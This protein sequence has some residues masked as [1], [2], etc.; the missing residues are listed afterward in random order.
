MSVPILATKLYILPPRPNVV[1]R[2]RLIERLN[3]GLGQ[4]QSF[5]RKLTLIS[6]PAGFGKTTLV[7][8]WVQSMLPIATMGGAIPTTAIAWLS[9]DKNDNDPTRF[10]TYLVAALQTIEGNLGKGAL[11]A[12][13]S[14]GTVNVE[15]VLTVL[16]NEIVGL[17]DNPSTSSGQSLVLVLDDYH[18]IESQPIDKALTFLLDHLPPQMHL[19]IVS[20]SDPSL[21]LSLLRAGGQM[22]EIRADDLRFTFDEITTFLDKAMSLDLSAENVTALETRTEGWIAGLQLAAISMQGLKGSSE[23]ADFVNR[24]TGSD[25]YIQDYLAEEVLQQRPKGSKDFLLQT[26]ILNRLS[27]PLCDAVRFGGAKSPSSS[28]GSAVCFGYTETSIEQK[29]SQAIL[30]ALQAANLFIVPLDNE[31]RWYRYH[32]LFAD[33][34]RQRLH[35]QHPDSVA[36]LHIRASVWYEENGLEIEAFHHATAANDVERAERLIKGDKIPLHSRGAASIILDWLSSL[37]TAVLDARP[38][39]WATY[40]SLLLLTGQ[41]TDVEEKLQAAEAALAGLAGLSDAELDDKTRNLVGQIAAS[42]ATLALTQY[43]VE[44]IIAQSHRAL[45]YLHPDNLPFRSTAILMLANAYELQGDRAAAG[46]AYTEAISI[47]QASGN[48][49][50]TI[51]ATIGLG[52]IQE[53]DNQ[54]YLAAETYRRGLQLFGDHPQPSAGEAH[55]GLA[56]IFYKWNDLDAAQQHGQQSLKLARQYDTAIDRFVICQVFLARLKLAHGDVDGAAAMLAEA[57]Q[58]VRQHNFVHRMPGVAAAQVLTLLH[59]GKLAAAA[60]LAEKYKLPISQARVHLAREDTD[61]AIALLGPLRQQMEAKGWQDER[62]KVMV[63]QA[64]AHHR[65]Q[66]HPPHSK[67]DKAVQL[68]GEALALA[69]PGGFIRIFV[70]EGL[71]M[72]QL[73]SKAAAQ[74]IMPDYTGKLLAVF[75]SE[76]QKRKDESCLPPD[77]LPPGIQPLIEPLT[78]RE[79]EVLQLIA[80]GRSNPEIAAQLVIAVTT[81]KTHVKNIYGKLQVT[82]RFQAAARANDLNL[83]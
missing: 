13:Q 45:E 47:S 30:E 69:E 53:L 70:D 11:V 26:S 22:T 24:F 50:F 19:V 66:Q 51:V 39:L 17:S 10:L 37:P 12:L 82:N 25:R 46:R 78:P 52:E 16:L 15:S 42:R 71:P 54:L 38:S 23:I 18:V 41:T 48:I 34:L 33:L 29:N 79:R 65:M 77:S 14:S 63:L 68:L 56:R 44:T 60:H 62:L 55:L 72:A 40:A 58:I 35:Q 59:Q 64:V 21:P 36:E 81:V 8:E 5:G 31:R 80:S 28:K 76:E 3:E 9:L 43:Q 75:E 73:L 6:A 61:K 49:F 32:H 1:L 20:R 27:G 7:S 67:K 2:P 74:E 57:G 4:S 83:L